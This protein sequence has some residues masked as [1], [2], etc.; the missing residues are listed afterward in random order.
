MFR[1]V[2][3]PALRPAPF[4][5]K[6]GLMLCSL[7]KDAFDDEA[8]VFEPKLDGLRVAVR[9]DGKK[10]TLLSRNDKSQDFQ[11]PDVLAALRKALSK[12]VILDG[13]IVCLDERGHSSFRRLQQRFH[14]TSKS[15]VERR[16]KQFPAY[17]YAFDILYFDRHDATDLPLVERKKLLRRAVRW[18]DRV[19]FTEFIRGKGV[20]ALREACRDGLEGIVAKR[21]DSPYRPVRSEAWL[22]IK[23]SGRQELVIGGFT[24]P[25]RTRVGLGALL[26]GYFSDDNNDFVYA[27]K[28]GTG[29]TNDVLRDLRARLEKIEQ[30]QS[31]FT[32]GKPPRGPNVHWVA[33]K[34]VAEIAFAEW[35]QNDLLRQPRF[36]GLREDKP[37]SAIHRERPRAASPSPA[38]SRT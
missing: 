11:F 29:F 18:N 28:V 5:R 13:E 36:E 30:K 38:R 35:T 8:W 24:D 14:L 21:L 34:L 6:S 9:F 10:L 37:A 4:P 7:V 26:V 15:E 31:P 27:G 22:K 1:G 32:R 19:R 20:A 16:A 17:L 2:V 12:R 23:C 25:Q 3:R 33:P